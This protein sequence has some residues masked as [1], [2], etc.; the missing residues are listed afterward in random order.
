MDVED[1]TAII[2]GGGTGVGRATGMAL[3]KRGCNVVVNYSRSKDEAEATA[4]DIRALGVRAVPTR[5]DV[6]R[7][8]DCRALVEV[9]QK[10]FGQLDVLVQSAGTTRRI[11]AESLDD[12]KDEDWTNIFAVNLKGAFQMA[13]AAKPLMDADGGGA[14]VNISSTSSLNALGTSIPYAASKAALN[15]LTMALARV[16][17]PSIRVN[18]VA[19]GFITG[20]WLEGA[21]GAAYETYKSHTE[22]VT[23]LLRVC[24]PEDVADA[25]LSLVTGSALIT[26]QVVVVDGGRLLGR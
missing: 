25:V 2:T 3:G 20:R 18:A 19:P 16:L 17:A 8:T 7:D 1:K 14:I 10:E 12:V 13:R 9:A 6:S 24:D 11:P 21:L 4:A 5:G 15:N 22:S 23:P 26:G